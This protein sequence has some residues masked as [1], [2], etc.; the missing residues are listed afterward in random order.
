MNRTEFISI[1]NNIRKIYK[2]IMDDADGREIQ[3]M[4]AEP[5]FIMDTGIYDSENY[6]LSIIDRLLSDLSTVGVKFE[7]MTNDD[8]DTNPFKP[9]LRYKLDGDSKI[10]H[11]P[12]FYFPIYINEYDDI[13]CIILRLTYASHLAI[14]AYEI[15]AKIIATKDYMCEYFG[16]HPYTFGMMASDELND[17]CEL[18]KTIG[19]FI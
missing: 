3:N 8:D 7:W 15:P 13:L 12:A 14:Y 10:H 18:F 19:G 2:Y 5:V 1:Q 6:L 9:I 17:V 16:S 11:L 4:C